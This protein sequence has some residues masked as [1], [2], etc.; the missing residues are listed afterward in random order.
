M[1]V[2][3]NQEEL[4][5]AMNLRPKILTELYLL[6]Q[7][8]TYVED[9]VQRHSPQEVKKAIEGFVKRTA[10]SIKELQ[11]AGI[12]LENFAAAYMHKS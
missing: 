7:E 2:T 10:E 9:I 3:M 8:L 5:H 4:V 1:K 11:A 6:K 12:S